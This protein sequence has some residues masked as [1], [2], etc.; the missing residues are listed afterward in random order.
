MSLRVFI[1]VTHLL[2]VGHLARMAA[3]GRALA[4]AGH[5]VLLASGGRPAPLVSTQGMT[6]L[7]LPPIHCVGTDFRTLLGDD[8]D[9]VADAVLERRRALLIGGFRA[10]A[11]QVLVTELFPF[12]RRQLAAEFEALLQAADRQASRPAVLCSIRDI[13]NPPSKPARADEALERLGRWY[14]RVLVH[15]DPEVAPLSLS[16]P[17]GPALARRLTYTGYIAEDPSPD[18]ASPDTIR[19]GDGGEILVSGGGSAASLP[20]FRAA[21]GAA[22]LL[23]ARRWRLLVGHGVPEADFATLAGAAPD[24][25]IVERARPDFPDLLRGC[26][27]SVSQAGYNTVVDVLRTGARSVL[28]AF[29]AGGEREQ[30]LRARRLE[31]LGL[32]AALPQQDVSADTVLQAVARQLAGPQ[33]QPGLADLRGAKASVAV[34]EA[35]AD[36][37]AARGAAWQR[38]AEALDRLAAQRRFLTV[39]WRDD[40]AVAPGPALDRLLE[41]SRRY[42]A[43]LGLAV[44]P[45]RAEAALAERLAGDDAVVDV[46]VHGF[47]HR[48][49]APP[50]EKKRELGD[51]PAGEVLSEL[52]EGLEVTRRLF[53]PR[54]LPV[55]VPPWNR[56]DPALLPQLSGI[57]FRGLSTF[58]RRPGEEA[59]AGVALVNTHGDPVAWRSGGGLADEDD[60]IV[61]LASHAQTILAGEDEPWGLLTHHLVHDPWT[62]RFVE[63]LLAALTAHGAVRFS[64]ARAAFGI[65]TDAG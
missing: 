1:A 55:L 33:P 17:V 39:W 36:R 3:I 41:L 49:H 22:A 37:A 10:F 54:A 48:N 14:D 7:Q 35:E 63:R 60:L 59:S 65:E 40:D 8:G 52:A 4:R 28:V 16:W 27:V 19:A 9:P 25:T 13:L 50:G 2:G 57:G 24:N 21:L 18:T 30:L 32:A 62:W 47:A 29:D 53:G 34:I 56:I 64:T 6:L 5:S 61:G 38:L 31:A 20:L 15:G 45:A 44:I 46:L 26:A 11:P 58:K 23:T 43:P 42:A 51:R 12:G